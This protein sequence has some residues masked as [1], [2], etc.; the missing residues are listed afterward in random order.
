VQGHFLLNCTSVLTEEYISRLFSLGLPGVY[1]EDELS[2]GIEVDGIISPELRSKGIECLRK[3]DIDACQGVANDIVGEILVGGALSLDLM[4][5]RSYDNYTH[6]HSVNVAVICG[7]IGMGLQL[8]GREIR[9]LVMAALLHDLGKLTIPLEILNKPGRLTQEEFAIIK[10]HPEKSYEMIKN[11]WDIPS[12]VKAAVRYHH[13]NVD[14]S[15]YPEGVETEAQSLY[16][17]IL[18]VADVYDALISRRPYKA[19]YS[20]YEV[21]EYLMGGCGIMFDFNIVKALLAHVPLY[22]KGTMVK[23]SDD[24][25]GVIYDNTGLH[26]LRPI[27]R[28]VTG[29]MIDLCASENYG[30]T[31]LPPDEIDIAAKEA[32]EEERKQMLKPIRRYRL[33]VVDDT[34][35]SRQALGD[36]LQNLYDVTLLK[37]GSQMLNYLNKR[38]WPDL[39]LMDIDMPEMDGIETARR[40]GEITNG[41][42]P[43]LFVTEM[44]DRQTVLLCRELKAAGYVLRPYNPSFIKGE[45]QR[46][47]LEWCVD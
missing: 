45:I 31:I 41:Q 10:S 24:R 7:V 32:L 33:V 1:I 19:P 28:L 12:S 22:P 25:E 3:C 9:E 34:P 17:K 21:S 11:R 4:D 13:K 27:I 35:A 15:G 39:I 47:L 29:E 37:S 26:N 20:P 16:T 14:G 30:L 42:I 46:I 5:L 18:H 43:I 23:L 8:E 2:K 44:C 40:I 38:T 36:I 6:A